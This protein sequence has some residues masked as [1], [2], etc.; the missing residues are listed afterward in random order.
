MKK[1]QGLPITTIIIAA[2]GI[3]VL[4]VIAAI[5]GGQIFKFG[6]V[7]AECPGACVK[8]NIP[9][10]PEAA[11]AAYIQRSP[12]DCTEFE[13]RASGVYVPKNLGPAAKDIGAFRCDVCCIP[14][15]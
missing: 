4:V 11:G 15:G 1:A 13:T 8:A 12:A 2:L 10:E 7:A 9:T 6:R 14:I 3:L 5:F